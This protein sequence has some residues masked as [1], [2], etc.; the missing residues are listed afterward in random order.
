MV[1]NTT[2]PVTDFETFAFEIT[3]IDVV[4]A[5]E[6]LDDIYMSLGAKLFNPSSV[7][8]VD[9]GRMRL[10][11]ER[12]GVTIGYGE[13]ALFNENATLYEPTP[14]VEGDNLYASMGRF[15][16]RQKT[17]TPFRRSCRDFS[18]AWILTSF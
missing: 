18:A 5:N 4:G 8:F 9:L 10:Y 12:N 2:A 1:P 3:G 11:I 13:S 14:L 17:A 16:A 6:E 15:N 7:S